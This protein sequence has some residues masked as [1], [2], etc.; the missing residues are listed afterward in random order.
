[1]FIEVLSRDVVASIVTPVCCVVVVVG[2]NLKGLVMC[3][4]TPPTVA[5]D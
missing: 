3:R 2:N 1:V 5:R 4:D